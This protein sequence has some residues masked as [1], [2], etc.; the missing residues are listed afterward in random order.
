MYCYHCGSPLD[1]SGYCP[2]CHTDVHLFK[3]IVATANQHYNVGLRRAKERDLHGAAESLNRSLR[4]YKMNTDARN[5]LGLVYYEMGDYPSAITEWSIS[6]ALQP[7][8]NDA[9]EYLEELIGGV[10]RD[11]LNQDIRKYNQAL[12][13]NEQGND[14]LALIQLKKVVSDLPNFIDARK[15]LALILTNQGNYEEAR[16]QI[17]AAAK[18]DRKDRELQRYL[19]FIGKAR[20]QSGVR[21]RQRGTNSVTRQSGTQTII[22]PKFS[23]F[24]GPRST[25]I[26]VAVGLVLGIVVFYFLAVPSIRSSVYQEANRTV[27]ELQ[28]RATAEASTVDALQAQIDSLNE[29]VAEYASADAENTAALATYRHL[30]AAYAAI[31]EDD[32]DTAKSELTQIDQDDLTAD[33][34]EVYSAMYIEACSEEMAQMYADIYDAYKDEDY[35]TTI[36]LAEQLTA[37]QEE[38]R[39]GEILLYLGIA[40]YQTGQTDAASETLEKVVSSYENYARVAQSYLDEMA[41]SD[42]A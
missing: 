11:D 12:I 10:R 5:L 9:E 26:N 29:E 33:E 28:E 36:E 23:R 1:E 14:D 6:R 39:D 22:E 27:V 21:R 16:A 13:Y 24:S 25:V 2:V 38:Y 17:R 42:E 35:D 15:L 4:L 41:S 18:I 30:V 8:Y 20:R 31:L 34:L 19:K 3:K 7:E 32:T 40:Y 37:I